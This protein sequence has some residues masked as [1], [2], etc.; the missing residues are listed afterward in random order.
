M[1]KTRY[2]GIDKNARYVEWFWEVLREITPKERSLFLRFVWGRSRLPQGKDF[3]RFT[4]TALSG[5]H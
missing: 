5:A 2:N 4:L 1:E 3:D